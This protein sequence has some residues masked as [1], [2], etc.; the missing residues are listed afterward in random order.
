MKF[1]YNRIENKVGF[2]FNVK[3]QKVV[4]KKMSLMLCIS[5]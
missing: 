5:N 3:V 1:I 2:L 4:M